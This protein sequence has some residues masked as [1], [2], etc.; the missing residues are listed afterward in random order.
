LYK[1]IDP[2]EIH[3]ANITRQEILDYY[4]EQ[5]GLVEKDRDYAR[6]VPD[7]VDRV[8]QEWNIYF[9]SHYSIFS[10]AST[11]TGP[12]VGTCSKYIFSFNMIIDSSKKGCKSN[13]GLGKGIHKEGCSGSGGAHGGFGGIGSPER[14]G[15]IDGCTDTVSEPYYFGEEARYEGSGGAAGDKDRETGGSGGG[16]IWITAPEFMYPRGMQVYAEGGP[17]REKNYD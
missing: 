5:Y 4:N 15:S 16:I 10:E 13:Q 2:E 8:L 17:G 9:L 3:T 14:G 11:I 1:C 12:R 7:M 6:Y